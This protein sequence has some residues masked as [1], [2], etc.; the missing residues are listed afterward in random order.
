MEE[1]CLNLKHKK[2]N[3]LNIICK[4]NK[5]RLKETVLEEQTICGVTELFVKLTEQQ[6]KKHNYTNRNE[7][8]NLEIDLP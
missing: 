8:T 3:N 1:K 5:N 7:V 6:L 2:D 4:I